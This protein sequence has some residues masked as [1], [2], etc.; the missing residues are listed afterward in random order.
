MSTFIE[1]SN[2]IGLFKFYSTDYILVHIIYMP[3]TLRLTEMMCADVVC[4]NRPSSI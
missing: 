3:L 4:N 2:W 1:Y